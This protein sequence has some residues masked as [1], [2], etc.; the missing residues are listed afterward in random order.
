MNDVTSIYQFSCGSLNY[1]EFKCYK[2][3]IIIKVLLLAFRYMFVI[4]KYLLKVIGLQFITCYL[5]FC[6]KMCLDFYY[7]M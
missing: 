3:N 7:I 1:F 2:N 6:V 5:R 4:P